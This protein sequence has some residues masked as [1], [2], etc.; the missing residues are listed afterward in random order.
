[1]KMLSSLLILSSI[2]IITNCQN[3]FEK[4]YGDIFDEYSHSVQQTDDN[5]FI[6][7]GFTYIPFSGLSKDVYIVKM[8]LF[9]QVMN[10]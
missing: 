10:A 8:D 1:M 6:L 4:T 3:C 2:S 9:Y 7:C 5:G